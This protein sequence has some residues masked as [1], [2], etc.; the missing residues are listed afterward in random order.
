M[1][2]NNRKNIKIL[3]VE[4]VAIVARDIQESLHVLGYDNIDVALDG[5][6]ALLLSQKNKYDLILMDVKL[7][8]SEKDGIEIAKIINNN[9]P[10]IY[11]TAYSDAKTIKRILNSPHLSYILKPFEV[12]KI[13]DIIDAILLQ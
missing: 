3:I 2:T 9:I 6:E 4:D 10:I 5:A 12:A 13:K 7:E 8:G 1:E 11:C